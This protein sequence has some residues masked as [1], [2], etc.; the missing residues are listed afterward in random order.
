[1]FNE[2]ATFVARSVVLSRDFSS[3]FGLNIIHYE[4]WISESGERVERRVGK[5]ERAG[6]RFSAQAGSFFC[7]D[8]KQDCNTQARVVRRRLKGF[9]QL[10]FTCRRAKQGS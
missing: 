2:D 8:A 9:H 3:T 6:S 7:A 1:M 5:R 10:V 4:L